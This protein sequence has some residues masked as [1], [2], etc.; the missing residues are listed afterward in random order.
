MLLQKS[1]TNS[2][3]LPLCKKARLDSLDMLRGIA[4]CGVFITHFIC[5]FYGLAFTPADVKPVLS[6]PLD[7]IFQKF[8]QFILFDKPRGMFSFLFGVG[9]YYQLTRKSG[10]ELYF[11]KQFIKRLCILF[12]F[13]LLHSSFF[14][15]G[16][17]LRYYAILGV[18]LLFSH[19]MDSR[20]LLAGAFLFC[21]AFPCICTFFPNDLFVGGINT[22]ATLAIFGQ[23][24]FGL[25]VGRQ[26]IFEKLPMHRKNIKK[27]FWLSLSLN[28]SFAAFR[29]I[30]HFAESKNYLI[31]SSGINKALDLS[32]VVG[33]QAMI[34]AFISGILVLYSN[35]KWKVIGRI[36]I[37]AG[38]M[39]LTN[40]V[41]QSVIAIVIFQVG[42]YEMLGTVTA[43]L[44]S[45]LL[46]MLQLYSSKWWLMYYKTGPLEWIWRSLTSIHWKP[47]RR[48]PVVRQTAMTM[49][50]ERE[51]GVLEP[52][53]STG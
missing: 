15:E 43:F 10:A 35:R 39:T 28:L 25:W 46:C 29:G 16:D 23:F 22:P 1:N 51:A 53:L 37:P 2:I 50:K 38:R 30:V 21:I 11:E 27:V 26:K 41:S 34:V 40:Y 49:N 12:L 6:T 18:L 19:R 32:F 47:E 48:A 8:L 3:D 31:I 45:I 20:F 4:L 7:S 24:L 44:M 42:L 5:Q 36:F 33:I 14:F 9:F 13:G 17:V 52:S